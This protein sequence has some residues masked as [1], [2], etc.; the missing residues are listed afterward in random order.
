MVRNSKPREFYEEST[1]TL[2]AQ[3][4]T[5][6]SEELCVA[7]FNLREAMGDLARAAARVE[8]TITAMVEIQIQRSAP[9]SFEWLS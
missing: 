8:K 9:R 6:A 7:A 4:M 2:S 1:L 5:N 3:R